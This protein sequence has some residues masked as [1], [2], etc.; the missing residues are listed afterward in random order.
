MNI[1]MEPIGS[2]PRPPEL[3][4]LL[5]RQSEDAVARRRRGDVTS[6]ARPTDSK[7]RRLLLSRDSDSPTAGRQSPLAI[8]RS[9]RRTVTSMCRRATDRALHS[10]KECAELGE[11][12]SI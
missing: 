8:E 11:A 12:S 5:H 1:L 3:I 7:A 10:L 9:S 4:D 2:V 6:M